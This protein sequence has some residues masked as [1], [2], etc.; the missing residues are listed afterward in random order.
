LPEIGERIRYRRPTFPSLGYNEWMRAARDPMVKCIGPRPPIHECRI[1]FFF[2]DCGGSGPPVLAC[3]FTNECRWFLHACV[4]EEYEPS[5]CSPDRTCCIPNARRGPGGLWPFA[6]TSF[7]TERP[8]SDALAENL[9]GWGSAGWDVERHLLVPVEV[10]LALPPVR[11]IVRCHG[12]D[13]DPGPCDAGLLDV[14]SPLLNSLYFTFR[15][16]RANPSWALSVEVIDDRAGELRARICRVPVRSTEPAG[17]C[18]GGPGAQC[19]TAGALR[20]NGFPVEPARVPSL[21]G[22]LVADFPDGA[23]IEAEF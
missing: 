5:S 22:R 19:A 14:A 16:P 3:R 23:H 20:L 15:T 2:A 1:G 6:R 13:G 9:A 17:D 8:F 4:S 7:V 18:G 12:V 21:T 11:P 10:D